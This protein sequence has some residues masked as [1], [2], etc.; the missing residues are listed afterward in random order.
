MTST[1][2]LLPN[3]ALPDLTLLMDSFNIILQN[4]I[5]AYQKYGDYQELS[6]VVIRLRKDLATF[7]KNFDN[8]YQVAQA[9][10]EFQ[11]LEHLAKLL[12]KGKSLVAKASKLINTAS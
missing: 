1:E 3:E 9:P 2:Y 11:Q 10:E 5:K 12:A 8:M 6:S 4:Q 7:I